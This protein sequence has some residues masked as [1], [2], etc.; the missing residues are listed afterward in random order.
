MNELLINGR[1]LRN[2]EKSNHNYVFNQGTADKKSFLRFLLSSNIE[3]A[4][5][6]E[7]TGYFPTE[8]YRVKAFG[9]TAEQINKNFGEGKYIIF[10]GNIAKEDAWTGTDGREFPESVVV[11]ASKIIYGGDRATGDNTV[12]VSGASKTAAPKAATAGKIV[13]PF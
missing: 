1:I 12:T 7:K 5:K 13:A 2:T 10:K 8:I 4:K 3:G 9:K 6:D 11:I